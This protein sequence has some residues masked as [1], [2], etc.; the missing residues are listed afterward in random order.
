MFAWY[1]WKIAESI[2]SPG[3]GAVC[4]VNYHMGAVNYTQAFC[5]SSSLLN[6]LP[7]KYSE[8]LLLHLVLGK[9]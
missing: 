1:T 6:Y 2:E 5:K 7:I 4:G 9:L 8:S 3:T